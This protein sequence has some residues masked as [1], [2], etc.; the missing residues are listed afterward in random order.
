MFSTS[1]VPSEIP[2]QFL[3]DYNVDEVVIRSSF[4]NGFSI[5]DNFSY[6][7]QEGALQIPEPATANLLL[8]GI[9]LWWSLSLV[10]TRKLAY[11]RR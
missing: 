2:T 9:V 11:A 4:L 1:F 3:F 6:S 8:P 10:R 5:M 7:L